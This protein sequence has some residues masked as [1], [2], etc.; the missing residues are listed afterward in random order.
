MMEQVIILMA[1][2]QGEQYLPEQIESILAQDYSNWKLVIQD[3]G[4]PDAT[5]AIVS[6]YAMK[7]PNKI[8]VRKNQENLGS[9]RNFL[10]LLQSCCCEA[11]QECSGNSVQIYYMFADQDDIWHPDKI[12][13]TLARMKQLERKYGS[14][15]PA[16]VFTDAAVVDAGG[17]M[18]A[19]SFFESQHLNVKK[20]TFSHLLMENLIIGCTMMMNHALAAECVQLP[21]H[22]RYH[23]WWMALLASSLGHTSYLAEATMDY[24]QHGSNVVGSKNFAEYV[25]GRWKNLKAQKNSIFANYKQAEEFCQLYKDKLPSRYRQQAERFCDLQNMGFARRRV[26]AIRL[27]C[28]KSGI[29]RNVGLMLIL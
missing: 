16:L 26:A 12:S 9:T 14:A 25:M 21:C 11:R 17:E 7:Y 10:K 29:A 8:F 5:M 2:Y 19:S 4:S 3:D 18:L 20:R 13:R 1:S 24:R 27:G 6:E 28:L 15:C 22:A 23:D